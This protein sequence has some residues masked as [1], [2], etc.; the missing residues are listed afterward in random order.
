MEALKEVDFDGWM[1]FECGEPGQNL[2]RAQSYLEELPASL[3]V[4]GTKGF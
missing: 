4:I 3:R 2:G 1:A